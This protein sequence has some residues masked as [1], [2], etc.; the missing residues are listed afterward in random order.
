MVL[1]C[2]LVHV[3]LFFNDPSAGGWL[4]GDKYLL[5]KCLT[6]GDTGAVIVVEFENYN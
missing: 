6:N 3:A 1:I 2:S 5:C 4:G